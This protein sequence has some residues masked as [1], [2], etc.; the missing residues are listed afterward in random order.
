M[1]NSERKSEAER[2]QPQDL[3]NFM[4]V[5]LRFVKLEVRP[6]NIPA[7]FLAQVRGSTIRGAIGR[8]LREISCLRP[9]I[10]CD[11][12][13]IFGQCAYFY[14][15]ETPSGTEA[16]GA[17]KYPY[18]PHPYLIE[19]PIDGLSFHVTLLGRGV[20]FYNN[21]LLAIERMGQNGLGN[22]RFRFLPEI[23]SGGFLVYKEGKLTA[24]PLV[25]TLDSY[26]A[27]R[28]RPGDKWALSFKTPTRIIHEGR[29]ARRFTPLGL[30]ASLIRR[31]DLLMK[32]HQEP[33]FNLGFPTEEKILE[34]VRIVED[35]T[36]PVQ[37]TSYSG[38][39][40]EKLRLQGFMGDVILSGGGKELWALLVAGEIVHVGKGT[41]FGFGTYKIEEV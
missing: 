23:F 19:P 4:G 6:K 9:G 14:L 41:S 17:R 22:M 35:R 16:V 20:E 3:H 2:E 8:S 33:G 25:M 40:K 34:G 13:P 32:I 30:V 10:R 31:L 27:S 12:C 24:K 38:R 37:H 39:Q 11:S 1:K 21:I 26:I 28:I 18:Y 5:G 29:L 36:Y 15:F 7:E